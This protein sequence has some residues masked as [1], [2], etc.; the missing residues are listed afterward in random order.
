MSTVSVVIPVYNVEKYLNQCVESVVTQTYKN[1][2]IILVDDGSKDTSGALCDEWAKKDGRIRVIHKTNGGLADAR[3]CGTCAA[4]G[5]WILYIDSDDWYETPD[6]IEK[7][8]SFADTHTSDIVCFNYRRYFENENKFSDA[9]CN[10][11]DPNPSLLYMVDNK[12]YTSSAC[13]KLIKR[14]I[15]T[16]NNLVF[17][18]GVLSEDIEFA[19]QLINLADK[20]TFCPDCCYIYRQ[21]S[22]SITA[23]VSKKHVDDLI[24]IIEKLVSEPN[25]SDEYNSFAAFQ[26]C[27][28]LINAHIAKVDRKTFKKIFSYKWLLQYDSGNIVKLV[29]TVSRL[30]GI[31]FCSY[32]LYLYFQLVLNRA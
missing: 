17:E 11:S 16:D 27:T 26:Y 24:Y 23:S 18:K 7:L 21:R 28:V 5:E 9:L 13:L 12:I 22:N 4:T 32:I 25:R 31:R 8:V 3:N 29:H 15:L 1:L 6:H 2:E 20:I 19:A 30:T 10:V 14:S